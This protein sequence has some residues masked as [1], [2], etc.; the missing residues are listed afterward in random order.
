MRLKANLLAKLISKTEDEIF[1]DFETTQIFR[2]KSSLPFG[3]ERKRRQSASGTAKQTRELVV[4][5]RIHNCK[6][7]WRNSLRPPAMQTYDGV[8]PA[9]HPLAAQA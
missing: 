9:L 5:N 1:S 4:A 7:H 8:R 2:T 3:A 6:R